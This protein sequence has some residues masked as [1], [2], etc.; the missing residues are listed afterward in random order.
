MY[1]CIYMLVNVYNNISNISL[2][3]NHIHT[4]KVFNFRTTLK[5]PYIYINFSN[6][7]RLTTN[8][9]N[10]MQKMKEYGRNQ[11]I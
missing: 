10:I 11:S 4:L 7:Q 2:K 1:V 8:D 3:T 5:E 6:S 9:L